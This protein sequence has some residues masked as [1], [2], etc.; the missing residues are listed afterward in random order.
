[1]LKLYTY[2]G[3]C[4]EAVLGDEG[5][6]LAG[7]LYDPAVQGVSP[8]ECRNGRMAARLL[9]RAAPDSRVGFV[10]AILVAAQKQ[11]EVGCVDDFDGENRIC[12]NQTAAKVTDD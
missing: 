11:P 8:S 4:Q 3:I 12:C 6:V 10:G 2:I 7:G 1:M 5:N 9:D